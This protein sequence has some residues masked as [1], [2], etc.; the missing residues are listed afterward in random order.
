MQVKGVNIINLGTQ[1]Y[2]RNYPD[3]TNNYA[4]C[5]DIIIVKINK[6]RR[7][8]NPGSDKEHVYITYMTLN[9]LISACFTSVLVTFVVY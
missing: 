9:V 3:G 7:E 5:D 6:R 4:R 1:K 2:L 8:T